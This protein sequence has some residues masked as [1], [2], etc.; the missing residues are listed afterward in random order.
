MTTKFPLRYK[1][2]TLGASTALLAGA[3]P[4]ALAQTAS[5]DTEKRGVCSQGKARYDFDV[6]KDGGRFEVNFEVDSNVRGQKWRMTL[7]HDGKRVFRDVRTT[8]REGEVEYERNRPNTAGNDAFRAR[9]VNLGN[10]EVCTA[11]IV[12]R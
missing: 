5:A 2:L 10:G 8:D 9:A 7:H 6:D 12:R 4:L 1:V 3:V 11:R